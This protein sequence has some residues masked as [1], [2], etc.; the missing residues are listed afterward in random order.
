M[1]R[2]TLI[3]FVKAPKAGRVKTRLGRAVGHGRAAEIFRKLTA[4]TAGEAMKARRFGVEVELAID[5]RAEIGNW[6]GLWPPA[7]RRAPQAHGSL[8]DRLVAAMAAAPGNGPVVV[9]GA[10]APGLRARHLR[11]AFAALGAND[12]VFGPAADGGFWLIGLARRR[13]APKLFA[14]VRWST[15]HAL[16][17]A[18]KSLPKSFRVAR[19]A[20][21]ADID[22]A[23]DLGRAPLLRSPAR[24]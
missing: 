3:V 16:K 21:L 23:D 17:D 11:E 13:Q 18:M 10:D 22:E 12:A 1:K 7:L 4:L 5:P 8:G 20:M 15:K 14:G 2:R 24:L 19:L 9:I 6:R